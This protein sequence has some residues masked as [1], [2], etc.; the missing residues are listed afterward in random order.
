[1]G[2]ENVDIIHGGVV[3]L[4]SKGCKDSEGSEY[5]VDVIVCATGFDLSFKPRFPIIGRED[6]NL[7]ELWA[8]EP[9]SYLGIA[10]AEMP[11]FFMFLGPYSPVG[12]GP[13]LSGIGKW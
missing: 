4:T 7:Q 11:N 9:K 12:N 10:A 8:E 5:V 13:T 1:M 6:L 3:E 2:R